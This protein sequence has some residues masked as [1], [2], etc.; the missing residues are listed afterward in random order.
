MGHKDLHI[1]TEHSAEQHWEWFAEFMEYEI[2]AG[3]PDPHL[4]TSGYLVENEELPE[5]IWM[6][7]CYIN[8]YNSPTAEALWNLW[9]SQDALDL[10]ADG[11]TEVLVSNWKGIATRRER[12]SVR[13]PRNFAVFMYDY[14]NWSEGLIM[15]RYYDESYKTPEERYNELWDDSQ[16]SVKYLGRYTCFKLLEFYRAFCDMP[17]RLPDIRPRGG[18]SPRS[19]LSILYPDWKDVLLGDD[20]NDNLANVNAISEDAL[21]VLADAGLDVDM[22]VLQVILCDYKQCYFS[23]RQF[24][25]RSQDSELM[26]HSK[27]AEYWDYDSDFFGVRSRKFPHQV[28]GELNGWDSVR[29]ELGAVLRDHGYMWSDLLYNYMATTDLAHPVEW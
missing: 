13:I 26:Y 21:D 20:S 9:S 24:P 8:P 28:L 12:K 22:F 18:W 15:S 29:K 5:R 4:K 23:R 14:A 17:I 10:G 11:M 25:G 19:M 27:I 3:G 16:K 7:G 1:A 2:A 6:G